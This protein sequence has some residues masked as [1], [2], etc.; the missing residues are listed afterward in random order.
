MRR[1]N[2]RLQHTDVLQRSSVL[3]KERITMLRLQTVRRLPNEM[4]QEV[5]QLNSSPI[6]L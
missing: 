5:S 3:Q 4:L 6:N 2:I 1:K